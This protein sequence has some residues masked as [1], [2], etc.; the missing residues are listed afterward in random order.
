MLPAIIRCGQTLRVELCRP[1][2]LRSFLWH[3]CRLEAARMCETSTKFFLKR[4]GGEVCRRSS[5]ATRR[6]L[7]EQTGPRARR[8]CGT[9]LGTSRDFISYAP[10][11]IGVVDE[12]CWSSAKVI[13]RVWQCSRTPSCILSKD[14]RA[15]LPGR[16]DHPM[17]HLQ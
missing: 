13:G 9:L 14:M 3:A 16:R 5:S 15:Y 12:N 11:G 10:S 6:A 7:D 17:Q 8:L 1:V 2:A 4:D